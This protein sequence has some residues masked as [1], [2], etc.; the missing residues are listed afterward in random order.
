MVS[1][2]ATL[3]SGSACGGKWCGR[4]LC[5]LLLVWYQGYHLAQGAFP[6]TACG[7]AGSPVA[8]WAKRSLKVS[9]CCDWLVSFTLVAEPAEDNSLAP[10]GFRNPG[11]RVV[12]LRTFG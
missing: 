12:L 3:G 6:L 4:V 9:C 8:S 7:Q 2:L 11:D 1:S 5:H 10:G